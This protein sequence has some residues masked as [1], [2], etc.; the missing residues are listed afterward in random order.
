MCGEC[1]SRAILVAL[2]A[3]G[4]AT[5]FFSAF[6]MQASLNGV[7]TTNAGIM[8]FVQYSIAFFLLGFAKMI[9]KTMPEHKKKGRR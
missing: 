1:I 3:G 2:F 5:L 4:F 7:L 6:W 8:L 9:K